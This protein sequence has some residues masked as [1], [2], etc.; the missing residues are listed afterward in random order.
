MFPW[1][2]Y[3]TASDIGFISPII[4]VGT[5]VYNHQFASDISHS[6][7]LNLKDSKNKYQP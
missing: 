3:Q 7:K 2:N 5:F 6:K 4:T 1:L